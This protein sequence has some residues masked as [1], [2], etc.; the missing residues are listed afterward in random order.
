ME[1]TRSNEIENLDEIKFAVVEPGGRMS[2]LKN[3]PATARAD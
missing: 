3:H 2:I 1:E